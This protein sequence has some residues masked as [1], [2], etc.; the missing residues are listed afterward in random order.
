LALADTC[1]IKQDNIQQGSTAT[2]IKQHV[3][4]VSAVL[5]IAKTDPFSTMV[6]MDCT[7]SVLSALFPKTLVNNIAF[8]FPHI[9]H[10]P[11]FKT[12]P[13]II[14]WAL[15]NNPT[16]FFDNPIT[17]GI[18]NSIYFRRKKM[19]GSEQGALKM[20]VNLFDWLD[21]LEPQPTTEIVSLC[22]QYQNIEAK[23]I[24]ILDQRAREVEIRAE[25]DRFMVTLKKHSA[26]SLLSYLTLTLE[27]Y[28]C[29]M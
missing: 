4:S 28:A 9:W 29:W 8:M 3:D 6:S 11:S 27:S 14:P 17:P 25:I 5:I 13:N 10:S 21:N 7:L 24:N 12:P 20:L 18:H 23:V 16:F 15:K 2:F 26:V 19:K 22:E 1:S